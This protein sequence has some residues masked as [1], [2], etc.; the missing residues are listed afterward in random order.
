METIEKLDEEYDED[1][2]TLKLNQSREK[3][4]HELEAKA[5]THRHNLKMKELVRKE[6]LK[7]ETS[8][9]TNV[10][11]IIHSDNVFKS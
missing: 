5:K 6:K 9:E 1:R 8:T 7:R 4:L 2:F 3:V 11:K 10:F